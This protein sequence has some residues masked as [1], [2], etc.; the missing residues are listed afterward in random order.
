MLRSMK[1]GDQLWKENMTSWM[2][3]VDCEPLLFYKSFVF[4]VLSPLD[5]QLNNKIYFF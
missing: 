4:I 1:K 2:F 5:P 3:P